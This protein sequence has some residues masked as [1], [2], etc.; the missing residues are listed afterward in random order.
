MAASQGGTAIKLNELKALLARAQELS[1]QLL[2]DPLVERVLQAFARLPESDRETVLQVLERDATWCRII[3]HTTDGTGIRVRPN[4]HASLYVHI[5]G[6]VPEQSP[7]PLRRD[8]DVIRFG[9]ETFAN[10]LPLFFQEGVHT[11]WLVAA[12]EVIR[13]AT[14][15]LRDCATRLAHEVLAL[16]EE[17]GTASLGGLE[18]CD[19]C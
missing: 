6:Q 9:I 14:P 15:E 18:R 11:Q 17:A 19:P 7:D 2:A 3:E 1:A 8:I 16:L 5:V 13:D 4:P 12:R 10:M